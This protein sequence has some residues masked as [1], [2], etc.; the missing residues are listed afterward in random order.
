[1]RQPLAIVES[2]HVSGMREINAL[3][4]QIIADEDRADANLWKQAERVAAQLAA[5]MTQRALAQQWINARTAKPYSQQHVS[6][7]KL[8]VDKFTCETSRPRFRD[9]YNRIANAPPQPARYDEPEQ[10]R[11]RPSPA[12]R[13]PPAQRRPAVE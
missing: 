1:M 8:T 5:G 2:I 10:P 7:V 4:K 11:D 3:E 6:Y 13:R 9:A 12:K